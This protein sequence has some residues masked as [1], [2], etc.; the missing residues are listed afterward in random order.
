[1]LAENVILDFANRRTSREIA[2]Q[3][4]ALALARQRAKQGLS[5]VVPDKTRV[6][7]VGARVYYSAGTKPSESVKDFPPDVRRFLGNSNYVLQPGDFFVGGGGGGGPRSGFMDFGVDT[8]VHAYILREGE[9]KAPNFIQK[10]F[11]KVIAGQWIMRNHMR[12]GMTAGESFDAM[13]KALEDEG[14]VH[15]PFT[16]MMQ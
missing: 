11:D 8:K 9:T 6:R 5:R 7:D 1:M 16:E 12:V 13:V 15:T 10:V 14:Y 2:A 4:E 3:V